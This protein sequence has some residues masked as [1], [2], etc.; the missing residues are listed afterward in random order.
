[1]VP[2]LSYGGGRF[3]ILTPRPTV[4]LPIHPPPPPRLWGGPTALHASRSL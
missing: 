4:T 1:V 2:P 3:N